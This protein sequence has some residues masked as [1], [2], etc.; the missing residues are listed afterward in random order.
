MV[1]GDFLK[2]SKK[3]KT[4]KTKR[5][6]RKG[7]YLILI[8]IFLYFISRMPPLLSASAQASYVI[9]YGKI[10]KTIA[11]TGYIAREE[12]VFT[13]IGNGDIKYFVSEGEK[14]AK[15]QKLAEIYLEEVDEGA[16]K[17]LEAINLRLQNIREKQDEKPFFK[18]DVEKLE[19][20]I[21]GLIKLIQ[22]DIREGNYNKITTKKRDLEN[23][24][25]KKSI[26]Q[27]EKS[28]SG[29]NI[30]QLE[31]QKA[32]LEEKIASSVQTIY[33]NSSGF[34]AT[35]SDGL[36]ELLNY[37][38]LN[39]IT[40]DQLKLLK[41]KTR[42]LSSETTNKGQTLIRIIENYKWSIITEIDKDH[43]DKIKK[44]RKI[45]LRTISPY[46]ELD[47][48]VGNVIEAG[49]KVIVIF[50][51]DQFIGDFYN[52][53]V[54]QI[55][56]ITEEYEGAMVANSSI[57]EKEGVKGVYTVDING[58]PNFRPI[59]TKISNR[60]YSII[61]DT[62][63]EEGSENISGEKKRVKTINLY[64]EVVS[65]GDKVKEGRRIR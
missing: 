38:L 64:D 2:A 55:E 3:S 21:G 15:G 51:L 28:F 14:I 31:N 8:I 9:E 61:F 23:L 40:N 22:E 6:R 4:A 1:A 58:M 32:Q 33:S 48:I 39:E 27:G 62:Y 20:E 26:I 18:R 63:F 13:N 12:K 59:K 25:N 11:S 65:K 60:G 17:D 30:E 47:A 46:K 52:L 50:D 16:I 43:R 35:A 24:L 36:E 37:N 54:V 44:G 7:F 56:I 41:D 10:E 42:N 45:K 29:K 5:P 19:D 49:D 57:T 34:V 53:R